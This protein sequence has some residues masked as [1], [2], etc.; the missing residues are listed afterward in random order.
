MRAR[1]LSHRIGRAAAA[2]G[3]GLAATLGLASAAAAAD[4]RSVTSGDTASVESEH[5][6]DIT[7]DD[8]QWG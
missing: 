1:K 5:S 6:G 4:D 7:P 8:T 2:A 3:F